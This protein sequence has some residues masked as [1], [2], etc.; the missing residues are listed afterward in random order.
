[1]LI[2][3]ANL[4]IVAAE[5]LLTELELILPAARAWPAGYGAPLAR[6]AAPSA[7]LPEPLAQAGRLLEEMARR[8]GDSKLNAELR[9]RFL[10][11]YDE[12]E[13]LLPEAARFF[14]SLK[15]PIARMRA[16]SKKMAKL[17]EMRADR[18]ANSLL[19][20]NIDVHPDDLHAVREFANSLLKKRGITPV[21]G[22]RRP[23]R[24]RKSPAPEQEQPTSSLPAPVE[25]PVSTTPASSKPKGIDLFLSSRKQPS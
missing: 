25:Q 11:V 4:A 19:R 10:V 1:M 24:P 23:G 13:N 2:Q 5:A 12:F 7:E 16:Q 8:G 14:E 21:M 15:R 18:R 6:W 22:Q 17:A 20:A 3:P 9:E